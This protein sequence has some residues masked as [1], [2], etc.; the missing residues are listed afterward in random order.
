ML[1]T[2]KAILDHAHENGYAVGAFN[3]N[4]L[5]I[6]QAVVAAGEELNSPLI[7]QTSEGAIKYAG[8]DYLSSMVAV[9]ASKAKIPI[10]LH[11]DHGTTYETIVGCIAS[12]WTSVMID[13]SHHPLE[14]NIKETREI[15]KIAHAAGVSVE[16]ELG[17]LSGQEDQISV[18]EKD[19]IYTNP[20]EAQTFVKETGVDSLAI[21][22]GTAHG[23]YKGKPILDFDRLDTIKKLLNMPIV[24]HGASGLKEDDIAKAVTLGV[25]KINIDTDIRQAFASSVRKVLDEDPKVY[26]PRKILG[27]SKEAMKQV[28][29]G[30]IKMFKSENK[31]W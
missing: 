3:I 7:L 13:A 19:A 24:L 30:K 23:P 8:M 20:Q 4:N 17:R 1:V 15:V 9:A 18:D 26:D 16:A 21:A 14:E 31:A 29:M 27:P 11:L 6:L 25:N 22:I 10:A 12:G 2:G 28:V 5:E